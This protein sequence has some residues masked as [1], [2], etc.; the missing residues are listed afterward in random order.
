MIGPRMFVVGEDKWHVY[1]T[2]MGHSSAYKGSRNLQ[3]YQLYK[4][5][6]IVLASGFQSGLDVSNI[7]YFM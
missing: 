5:A 1:V 6:C 7:F 2:A 3:L 4:S